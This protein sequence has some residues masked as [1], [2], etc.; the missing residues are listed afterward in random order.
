M[1]DPSQHEPDD[2]VKRVRYLPWVAVGGAVAT[3]LSFFCMGF[4]VMRDQVFGESSFWGMIL[5]FV[6]FI[7][8]ALITQI[9]GFRFVFGKNQATGFERAMVLCAMSV[10]AVAVGPFVLSL[11]G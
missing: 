4:A 10:A 8:A 5:A 11:L 7:A 1:D 2:S 6:C 3:W 9:A